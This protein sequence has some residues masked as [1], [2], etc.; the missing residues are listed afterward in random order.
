MLPGILALVLLAAA[1]A[2]AVGLRTMA[3]GVKAR[4][5]ASSVPTAAQ[6]DDIREAVFRH[7]FQFNDSGLQAG[8]AAYYLALG[9]TNERGQDP[10]DE[11]TRR[12]EGDR[13]PVKKYSDCVYSPA[14]GVRDPVTGERGLVFQVGG[15][16][17]LKADR[18]EVQ[19]SYTEA[20]LGG[21][22]Y[23]YV[24]QREGSSW[25]VREERQDW[26]A[27]TDRGRTCNRDA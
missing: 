18:V 5:L 20:G 6:E 11:F 13:P 24:L 23:T 3:A 27:W 19:G 10:P 25:V 22:G 8:A 1:L 17:W 12:F 2:T 21:A 4:R 9:A 26:I 16:R 15:I 14:T 7:L